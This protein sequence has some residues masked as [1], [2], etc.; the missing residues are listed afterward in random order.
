MADFEADAEIGSIEY[1]NVRYVSTVNQ[2]LAM[3][4]C[5]HMVFSF[6]FSHFDQFLADG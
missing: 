1:F 3:F 2:L 6:I 5:R 4:L